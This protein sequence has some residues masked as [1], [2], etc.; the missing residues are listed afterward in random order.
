MEN[1]ATAEA[2]G[3]VERASLAARQ[4]AWEDA[5]RRFGQLDGV[6]LG[7][8]ELEAFA[9]AA[10]WTSH[11]DESMA[12]RQ[13]AYAALVEAGADRRAAYAAWFLYF[14]SLWF[15]GNA[16]VASGWFRRAERHLAG[17]PECVE[18]GYLAFARATV[19][20]ERGE[21]VEAASLAQRAVDVG[22]RFGD[23]GLFTLALQEL[24]HVAVR[25]GRVAEGTAFLD[26]AMCSVV[27]D[28]LHP[29]VVGWVFCSLLI[30]CFEM[31]DLTRAADWTDAAVSW[32]ESLP[33]VTPFHGLCR[34]HRVE[35]RTL[36]GDWAEAEADAAQASDELLALEPVVA[37]EAFYAMGEVRRRRGRLVEA[38]AAFRRAHELGRDPQPGLALVR[39]AQGDVGGALTLLRLPLATVHGPPLSRA[40]LLA[41]Q[42]DI[43]LAAGD[44]D[45]ARRASAEL[46]RLASEARSSVLEGTAEVAR[47]A[48]QLAEGQTEAAVR[49]AARAWTL[50]EQ[51]KMP[52]EAAHARVLLGEACSG[53]GDQTRAGMELDAAAAAFAR[54]GAEGDLRELRTRREPASVRPGG[55]SAR[56]AEVLA[57]V[58]AGKTNRE[59]ASQLV[60]SEHT[61][62]RHLQNIFT[63]LQVSSR[64]AA[65]AF[66]A[67]HGLH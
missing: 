59:I 31:A 35:V 54:L 53:V 43:S 37:G 30:T 26:E 36:R 7:A 18:Q 11:L 62:S 9:D 12:L 65:A 40:R 23:R 8:D 50:W 25:Q 45:T 58:A 67:E 61:V 63:K 3:P 20:E 56:E 16:S 13:R 14:D 57:L 10:W 32:C 19:A 52:Y 5:Y 64:A 60:L 41:A 24:G 22:E 48:L 39:L 1:S 4:R 38:E 47:A 28:D 66:A 6:A 27:T 46:D 29:I 55:L 34:V 44:V 42:V 21:L 49:S 15:K 51:L 2:I 17:Q 33:H